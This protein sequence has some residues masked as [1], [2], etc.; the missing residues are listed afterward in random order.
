M[1]LMI[2]TRCEIRNIFKAGCLTKMRLQERD[3]LYFEGGIGDRMITCGIV[4]ESRNLKIHEGTTL[5]ATKLDL[6]A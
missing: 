3:M 6:L 5:Q 2:E 1:R 4:S